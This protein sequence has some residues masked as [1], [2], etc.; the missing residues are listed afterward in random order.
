MKKISIMIICCLILLCGCSSEPTLQDESPNESVST[1]IELE[2]NGHTVYLNP[3]LTDNWI[4]PM[5]MAA[6]AP[7]IFV[8]SPFSGYTIR[9]NNMEVQSDSTVEV[10]IDK[11]Y[12]K[13]SDGIEIEFTNKTN[14][15]VTK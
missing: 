6:D 8:F 12:L 14:G 4:E 1:T 9:C 15:L 3:T 11:G 7:N 2:I 13:K 10:V 5:S